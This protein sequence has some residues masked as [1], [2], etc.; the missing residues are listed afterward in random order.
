MALQN[1]PIA[2]EI[3]LTFNG[4]CAIP[5]D[6]LSIVQSCA[7]NGI[8][9]VDISIEV[10][11]FE[12]GDLRFVIVGLPDAAIKESHDRVFSALM[13]SS[14]SV[15]TSRTTVNLAPSYIRKEGS[16]Y[17]LPIALGVIQGTGQSYLCDLREFIIAGELSLSGKIRGI[18]GGLAF[19]I[20]AKETGKK[21]PFLRIF[22]N[23]ALGLP[24]RLP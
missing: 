24:F 13:N 20:R 11:A 22:Q 15:P 16:F 7:L 17:D 8:K 14:Y 6:M 9:A 23:P 18:K 3:Y 12:R 19:A 21:F 4:N 10:N 1:S 5:T 2:A